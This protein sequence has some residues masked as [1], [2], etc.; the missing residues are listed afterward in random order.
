MH[1]WLRTYET[2]VD[3]FL[4]PSQFV[5][6]KLIKNSWDASRIQVLPHF[7][8]VL[9]E[10]TN[11]KLP[12]SILYFGRLSPE[13]GVDDLLRAMHHVP[14]LRLRIAG[15]GPQRTE[16]E[17][18]K[19]KLRVENVQFL[20]H[21]GSSALDREISS[22]QFTILPSRAYETLGKSILE[23]Y[24]RGRA[25]V[26]SDV[27]SRREL[28][29]AKPGCCT[30]LEISVRLSLLS[31][32]P[33]LASAMGAA[34]RDLVEKRYRPEDHYERLLPIYKQLIVDKKCTA[35]SVVVSGNV[36]SLRCLCRRPRVGAK[37]SGIETYYEE[38]G[39]HL[40]S[41]GHEITVYCRSHCTPKITTYNGMRLIR[42]PTIRSKHLETAI[43]TLL[44]AIHAGLGD[45]DIVH[46]HAL[47]PALFSFIPRLLGKKTI[48]TVQG[49]D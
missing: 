31:L 33:D 29:T 32:Q 26:A 47:G 6:E 25:V 3:Q 39:K 21:L 9:T 1:S 40:V 37:Y 15:D 7:Q 30:S 20:G 14:N 44:S 12:A 34:G 27:G 48:V 35:H 28:K 24:A 23:S 4:A 2:C 42:P 17:G 46:F 43:H 45:F 16:L 36:P 19:N 38:A 18:L 13:K 22:S 41:M 8:K 10:I 49:L 11:P 5:R